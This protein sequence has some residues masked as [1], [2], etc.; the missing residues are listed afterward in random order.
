MCRGIYVYIY[1]HYMY[2]SYL[3]YVDVHDKYM[4]NNTTE[5]I[6]YIYSDISNIILLLYNVIITQYM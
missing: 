1:I 6:Q 5:Y 4:L 3:T 2:I